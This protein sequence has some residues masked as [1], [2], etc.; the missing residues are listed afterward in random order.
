[1]YDKAYAGDMIQKKRLEARMTQEELAERISCS[2]RHIVNLEGGTIGM[3]IETMLKL[4]DLFPITPNDLL[5][6]HEQEEG[7][8]IE[9]LIHSLRSMDTE[10]RKTAISIITPY[11][12]TT[13]REGK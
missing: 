5:F 12:K 2:V 6:H 3:S 10:S 13:K 7:A 1:M 11:I 4:C 9:W 8:S